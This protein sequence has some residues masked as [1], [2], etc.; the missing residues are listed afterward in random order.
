M[1]SRYFCI[2]LIHD[3]FVFKAGF[4]YTIGYTLE[5]V[6]ENGLFSYPHCERTDVAETTTY[7]SYVMVERQGAA[8]V[9]VRELPSAALEFYFLFFRFQ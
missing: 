3:Y 9:W 4:W 2:F 8:A 1:T 5:P 7:Y 6:S